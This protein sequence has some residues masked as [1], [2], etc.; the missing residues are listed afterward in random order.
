MSIEIVEEDLWGEERPIVIT[1]YFGYARSGAVLRHCLRGMYW[2]VAIGISPEEFYGQ[3]NRLE[4][5]QD[6]GGSRVPGHAPEVFFANKRVL[7]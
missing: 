7:E 4:E 5:W 1:L 2:C 6:V 3:G